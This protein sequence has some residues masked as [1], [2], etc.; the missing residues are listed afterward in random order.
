MS[1]NFEGRTYVDDCICDTL[2]K[3]RR[4]WRQQR[5][6]FGHISICHPT[7]KITLGRLRASGIKLPKGYRQ[8]TLKQLK[9]KLYN[10]VNNIKE[11]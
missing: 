10:I 6:I 1:S 2:K 5:G 9:K 7:K 11:E 8:M 4:K 3:R